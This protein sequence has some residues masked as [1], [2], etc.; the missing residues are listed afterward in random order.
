MCQCLLT[1]DVII[2]NIV[3]AQQWHKHPARTVVF[4]LKT[5]DKVFVCCGNKWFSGSDF[6]RGF[7]GTRLF[8]ENATKCYIEEMQLGMTS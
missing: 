4:I 2:I 7:D 1:L 8:Q 6:P 5:Y 3:H